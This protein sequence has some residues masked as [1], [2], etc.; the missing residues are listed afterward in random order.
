MATSVLV[1]GQIIYLP[2]DLQKTQS[3]TNK[4]NAFPNYIKKTITGLNS[5]KT[6]L[7]QFKWVFEDG[8][9]SKDWSPSYRLGTPGD[10]PLQP[11]GFTSQRIL[12]GITV[13]WT[14]NYS[15]GTFFNGFKAINIYAGTSASATAGTYTNYSYVVSTKIVHATSSGDLVEGG[16]YTVEDSPYSIPQSIRGTYIAARDIVYGLDGSLYYYFSTPVQITVG[17]IS[18]TF[19][20]AN[21]ANLG[22]S[23]GGLVWSSQQSSWSKIGRAHV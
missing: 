15:N 10:P 17:T 13:S 7:I 8:S 16:S 11:T 19:N 22:T 18:D 12:G 21:A 3:D 1:G 6:Y 5:S 23:S 4:A 9:K 14:G 20:R 2:Q